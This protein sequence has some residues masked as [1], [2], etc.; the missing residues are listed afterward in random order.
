MSIT[1]ELDRFEVNVL[2]NIIRNE[3]D[4][5]RYSLDDALSGHDLNYLVDISHKIKA[6]EQK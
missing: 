4:K 5:C 6:S 3:V 1:I 2:N